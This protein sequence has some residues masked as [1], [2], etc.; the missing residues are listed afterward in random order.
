MAMGAMAAGRAV[1]A[2]GALYAGQS[3]AAALDAQAQIQQ[4][5]AAEDLAAGNLNAARTQ[6][7][8]QQKL[9]QIQGA[10]AAGGVKESGSVLD[11]MAAS[12]MNSEL[13][14]QNVLHGAEIRSVNAENQ[15]TMDNIG[16]QSAL[17]G[18][19]FSAAGAVLTGIGG[20]GALNNGP[21]TPTSTTADADAEAS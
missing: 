20:A 10:A 8:G 17:T 4:D 3:Q 1:Q 12:S 15:A 6:I 9:G 21:S 16:A 13:D 7:T 19:Y 18:S 14:R 5:N 2:G 11:V